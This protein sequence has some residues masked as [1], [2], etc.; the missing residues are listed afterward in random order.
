M[1]LAR[2]DDDCHGQNSKRQELN[3][4]VS[5]WASAVRWFRG[6]QI[7]DGWATSSAS[8]VLADRLMPEIR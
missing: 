5:A 2:I 6:V 4:D 8:C 1:L 3:N 7:L